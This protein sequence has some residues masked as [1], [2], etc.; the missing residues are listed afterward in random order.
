MNQ[1]SK[2][3]CG[4]ETAGTGAFAEAGAPAKVEGD[5]PVRARSADRTTMRGDSCKWDCGIISATMISDFPKK[6]ILID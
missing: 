4:S 1:A 6:S 2:S 3:D 5:V